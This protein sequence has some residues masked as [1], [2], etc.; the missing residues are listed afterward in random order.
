MDNDAKNYIYSDA[1]NQESVIDGQMT[2]DQAIDQKQEWTS[3]KDPELKIKP[4][5][6]K[7]YTDKEHDL[8]A[9][10]ITDD[11]TGTATIVYQNSGSAN[12][13]EELLDASNDLTEKIIADNPKIDSFTTTGYERGG[14]YAQNSLTID[15]VSG[16]TGFSS[17]DISYTMTPQELQIANSKESTFYGDANDPVFLNG[18]LTD[19]SVTVGL[20][21]FF[22][23]VKQNVNDA[24][25]LVMDR[26]EKGIIA[27]AA[28]TKGILASANQT[29][30]VSNQA[31]PINL[32][33]QKSIETILADASA[34]NNGEDSDTR[35]GIQ[36]GGVGGSTPSADVST[37]SG[38]TNPAAVSGGAGGAD[39]SI[40]YRDELDEVA[41]YLRA[42]VDPKLNEIKNRNVEIDEKMQGNYDGGV[43]AVES[44]WLLGTIYERWELELMAN[45]LGLNNKDNYAESTVS[46]VD[47]FIAQRIEEIDAYGSNVVTAHQNI[48]GVD[49]QER[50]NFNN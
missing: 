30:E 4:E 19:D 36:D 21:N 25:N 22:K 14:S 15:K 9:Y 31:G 42:I 13:T 44:D 49:N 16:A 45:G 6:I 41:R 2:F 27:V 32:G 26:I 29:S 1:A 10:V 17:P 12:S 39:E 40:T 33:D 23:D 18:R 5:N 50:G 46:D 7:K 35:D 34:R 28:A 11:K 3:L 24:H 38:S 20:T 47:Q 48:I 37:A 8:V 43:G